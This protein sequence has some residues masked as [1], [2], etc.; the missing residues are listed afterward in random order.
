[1]FYLNYDYF[2]LIFLGFI[3]SLISQWKIHHTF[4]KYSKIHCDMSGFESSNLVLRYND[5]YN[6]EFH[7][8]QGYLSDHFNPLDNSISL[9]DEIYNRKS[10]SAAGVG[11]HEAGHAVQYSLGY[12]P[13]RLRSFLVPI[14]NFSSQLA[15]PLIFLGFLLPIQYNFVLDLGV[16]LFG[17]SVIFHIV[18]LP[19][20]SNA[21]HRAVVALEQSGRFTSDELEGIRKVLSAARFTYIAAILTSF[22]S[23]MRLTLI[24]SD[25]RKR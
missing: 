17:F 23:L 10:I 16:M 3:I 2:P 11:A 7:K 25:R 22:L 18:T 19:V 1:M 20:E 5:V 14:T 13:M 6:V 21:S 4:K 9:S 24:S 15:S 12:F 8:T